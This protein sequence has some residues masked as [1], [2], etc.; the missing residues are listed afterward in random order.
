MATEGD[1]LLGP[2]HDSSLDS[3]IK[4][5]SLYALALKCP[6]R[7]SMAGKKKKEDVP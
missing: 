7:A 3:C 6:I 4:E 2:R 5:I 1:S